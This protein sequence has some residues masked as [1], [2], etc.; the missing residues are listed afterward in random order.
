MPPF[1]LLLAP[2]TVF[3]GIPPQRSNGQRLDYPV[4]GRDTICPGCG[5]EVPA[6]VKFCRACGRA[7]T[8]S[9]EGTQASKTIIQCTNCGTGNL[10]TYNVCIKCGLSLRSSRVAH[11]RMLSDNP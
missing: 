7:T 3:D 4:G 11:A 5:T 1:P 10:S 2:E 6:G 9:Q 8:V